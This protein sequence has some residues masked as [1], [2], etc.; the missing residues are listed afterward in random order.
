MLTLPTPRF[1]VFYNGDDTIPERSILK[2]SDSFA[3]KAKDGC[4]EVEAL[5]LDVNIGRNQELMKSCRYL[6]EYATFVGKVKEYKEEY[7]RM[8]EEPGLLT[9]D[10]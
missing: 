7:K 2:L 1:V 6:Q 8:L 10:E 3:S 9:S 4:L 5:L